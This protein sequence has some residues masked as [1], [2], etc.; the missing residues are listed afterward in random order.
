MI[1]Q[2]NTAYN[3]INEEPI[4]MAMNMPNLVQSH[5]HLVSSNNIESLLGYKVKQIKSSDEIISGQ[6]YIFKDIYGTLIKR[7]K[8]DEVDMDSSKHILITPSSRGYSGRFAFFNPETRYRGEATTETIPIRHED[9][10]NMYKIIDAKNVYK[11]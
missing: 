3:E 10:G 2:T 1:G 8:A 6:R 5:L 9:I 11:K 7:F 4:F